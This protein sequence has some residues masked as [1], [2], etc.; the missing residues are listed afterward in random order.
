MTREDKCELAISKGYNY[1]EHTG[2]IFGMR[3]NVIK[4]KT[5]GYIDIA[6]VDIDDD[7]T[8]H[9]YGHQFAWYF[10]NKECVENI[11]HI[12]G[13]KSDN[14][15]INLRNVTHQENHFNVIKRKGYYWNN[16]NN[17]W[18]SQITLDRKKIHLGYFDNEDDARQAYLK[19]KEKYHIIKN[20]HQEG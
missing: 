8:I 2:E 9:L 12:N 14:R 4:R 11:D 20:P 15:I 3:G 5:N 19:A 7:K 6:I 18:H 1:N 13:D 16:K 10:I 17:K